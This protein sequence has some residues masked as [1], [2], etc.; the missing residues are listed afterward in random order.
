MLLHNVVLYMK[1]E[2]INNDLHPLENLGFRIINNNES[3]IW[4]GKSNIYVATKSFIKNDIEFGNWLI[5]IEAKKGGNGIVTFLRI[6]GTLF[7]LNDKIKNKRCIKSINK[8]WLFKKPKNYIDRFYLIQPPIHSEELNNLLLE[9][10]K[11]KL[12]INY[13]KAKMDFEFNFDL[14]TDVNYNHL[15]KMLKLFMI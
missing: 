12:D 5:N 14:F 11:C 2:I 13:D 10:N 15:M 4:T 6:N 8:I 3:R 1:T 7:L 9:F